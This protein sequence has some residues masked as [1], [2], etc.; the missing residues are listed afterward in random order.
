MK[1]VVS[2]V[3][4]ELRLCSGLSEYAFG[5]TNY[6][7]VLTQKGIIA[8]ITD[9]NS[10]AA[11]LHFSFTSWNFSDIKSFDVE[12]QD[13]R[14]VFYCADN[15]LSSKAKTLYE[16]FTIA[17]NEQAVID[18]KNAMYQASLTVCAALTQ[19]AK[20]EIDIPVIGAG[21]IIVDKNKL[22][23]LPHDV[24]VHSTAGLG[25][26]EQA[27][28]NS[29]WV[30]PSLAAL[31]AL[32]F[33]RASIAYKMLT[34]RFAYPASDSLTR[35][36]DILDRKFLPLELS[37]NGI[38][39]ELAD[40]VNKGLKLNSNSVNIP[41]KKQK[42]KKSE[43][44]IPLPDFPL[45][46]LEKAKEITTATMSDKE[47]EEKVLAYKKRQDSRVNTS[48][49]LRRNT[50]TITVI[51]VAV[52][53]VILFIRSSYNNY[54]SE[55]TT[56]GLS[57]VQ[58]IQ[59]FFKGVNT[60]DIPLMESF[61]KG[62]SPNRYI[63]SVS[64]VYVISKQRQ[65]AAG[66]SGYLKPAKYFLT[67]TDRSKMWMA[68]LYGVTKITIDGKPVD[69]YIELKKNR[70]KPEPITSEQGI[71]LQKGDQSVHSVEYYMIHTEGEDSDFYLAKNTDTFTLTYLKNKW[72]ITNI[73]SSQQ[74]LDLDSNQF[75]SDYFTSI[76]E[77]NGDSVKAIEQ[78]SFKYNFLP[79]QKEMLTEQKI[80]TEYLANPYKDILGQ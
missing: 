30:N 9:K 13:E 2:I 24:F 27:D 58:T 64:N 77:N 36:A 32:C 25:T 60:M 40:A 49:T 5:K 46:I 63:D 74:E 76:A 62:R 39:P 35:N 68:G 17:G 65:T 47:F 70:D 57:S 48:R 6:N 38:N 71:T 31:P 54:L 20:E 3:D 67:I 50:T 37:I 52:I 26:I 34:G 73:E 8:E 11:N 41:G 42:G 14:V 43:E 21:G 55:Y 66:D 56:K 75:K 44:L 45:E 79:S 80:L 4:G 33:L 1:N 7:S 51:L 16:L 10:S 18:D 12:G 72:V 69:E 78:L 29:C 23:F 15:P 28:L 22:L 59:T 53:A 61:S 19:A